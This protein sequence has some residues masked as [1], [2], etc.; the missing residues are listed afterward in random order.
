MP[1]F[2]TLFNPLTTCANQEEQR[3]LK[4]KFSVFLFLFVFLNSI[5]FASNTNSNDPKSW[6]ID[7]V[8]K[9]ESAGDFDVSPCG[10]WVVWVKSRPD[11]KEN[12]TVSD[13]MLTSLEDSLHI[14]LTR[15]KFSDRSPKWSPDGKCIAFL[16]A[17]EKEKGAQVWLMNSRGGEPHAVTDL[18]KGARQFDWLDSLHIIFSARENPSFYES[19]LK[20][21]KDDAIVV[22]DQEH[23]WPVRLFR[24]DTKTKKVERLTTNAGQVSEFA[25]SPDG[26]WI[27]TNESQNVHYPYD[28]R[29]PPKQFLINLKENTRH[30]IFAE[31]NMKPN[32]FAW[33]LDGTGFY[34]SQPLASNPNDDYVSVQTLYYF[35]LKTKQYEQVPLDW[36]WR[37]GFFGFYVTREGVLTSLAH[38]TKNKLA[39]YTKTD[40][41]WKR[42]FL[43]DEQSENMFIQHV[44]RNGEIAI[45]N[46]ST[47]GSLPRIKWGRVSGNKLVDQREI[48]ELNSY[49]KKKN[50]A[51]AE[52]I[53]WKGAKGDKVEG[54]L[55]YP[56]NYEQGKRYPLMA[57]IHGGPAGADIDA[58]SERWSSYP[59]VLAS[60]DC[61][62]LKVNYHGSGNYGLKWV[63]SIKEHYYEYEVPDILAGVDEVIKRGLADPGKLG[64][65]GWSNGAILTI[66]CVIET[67]RFKVCAPGA[68][69][70]NW[71]SDYG[72]CAFGAAFDNAYFGGPP[73]ERPDYYVKIS[74]LFQMEKVKTPTIIF[75]GEKD[76]SVPTEQGWEHYRALQQIGKAPV[77]FLL[78]PGEPH[79]FRKLSHQRRKMEEELAWFDTYLFKTIEKENE[80]LKKDSP[81]ALELKKRDIARTLGYYGVKKQ[82]RLIPELVSFNDT[83]AVG[84]FEVTRAQFMVF[85][86]SFIYTPGTDNFS[87]NQ[88]S[89]EDARAYC[90]WLSQ[91]TGETYRL[92]TEAE[93][94]MLTK[95]T[96]AKTTSE[97]T[98]DYWAGYS[99]NPDEVLMLDPEVA[100]L[101]LTG[102]LLKEVGEFQPLSDEL[103]IFDLCGN[104]AEWCVT[105]EGKG[106]ISGGSAITPIDS[107][108]V[109]QPPRMDYV[110]FR[111]VKSR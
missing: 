51:R 106:K 89:F 101:E 74:P 47:A 76:T 99:P 102:L 57:S 34:C 32:R 85:R 25:I 107:K 86:H 5:L 50:I 42:T 36:K 72:N 97:N 46:Y 64:I 83:L 29:I 60:K 45:F 14:Q 91:I 96:S 40:G 55:Y 62:T 105:P 13:L 61:F 80:A 103:M 22:G 54:I 104:V 33:T 100:E 20:E 7:D 27:V 38:G 2:L 28:N 108:N 98:L 11:F 111:V 59:N 63:E 94:N 70:V 49:L 73:W 17:R 44:S 69:D 53:D 68:G 78:F 67:D 19:K 110:G 24:L 77:R 82:G 66:A 30:E 16:S 58:F 95:S 18:E 26:N 31:K 1:R 21:K 12:K 90:A 43:E 15:G 23:F 81:L 109:Y 92:P 10:T 71:T 9:Q 4:A 87:I 93:M 56:H 41:S 84:R 8:L 79:G 52:V 37:L 39:F 88:V 48:I 75:F 35:D 6:T 3:M 65:M